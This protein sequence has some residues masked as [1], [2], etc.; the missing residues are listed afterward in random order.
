[1]R[2]FRLILNVYVRK[3][4]KNLKVN[5]AIPLLVALLA[6]QAWSTGA[7]AQQP[8]GADEWPAAVLETFRNPAG[9]RAIPTEQQIEWR[10]VAAEVE[11]S[12]WPNELLLREMQP[13]L[14]Q[15]FAA[16]QGRA[17]A[18]ALVTALFGD[19]FRGSRLD[20][21]RLARETSGAIRRDRWQV[22]SPDLD[23]ERFAASWQDRY[24]QYETIL[25]TEHY[26]DH[27]QALTAAGAWRLDVP[28]R[29]T[30][31][32]D[33][34]GLE[35]QGRMLVDLGR[36]TEG[37]SWQITRV[38]LMSFETFSSDV[39]FSAEPLMASGEPVDQPM[40]AYVEY[41]AQGVSVVDIDGDGDLDIF[42]PTRIGVPKLFINVGGRQFHE[43]G[44]ALGFGGVLGARS[45]YFFDWDND[46][47]QDALLLTV[48][49][50]FLFE[51]Q[52][53]RFVDVSEASS[54]HWMSTTGLT[55]ATV[56]DYD[57]DGLLDFYVANYG[58]LRNTPVEDYFDS[59]RGYENQ[60]FRNIGDGRFNMVTVDS[61]LND[62]NSRWSFAAL[63]FDYDEDD[64]QDLYV[65]NDYGPNQLFRNRGDMTFEDVAG[66]A[67]AS[68]F[69]NGMGVSL[70]DLDGDGREDLYVSNMISH[71]GKRMAAGTDF[72]GDQDARTLLH[73]FA[74][75]NTVLLARSGSFA[76]PETPVLS[77]AKWAWGNVLF[78]YDND[79]DLDVYVTNGMFSN[80][81]RSDTDP[82]FWRHLLAPVA[83]GK[84][85]G[86][87]AVG[88]FSYLLQQE[89]FSFAGYER[90]RL[91]Q[92]FGNATFRDVAATTGADLVLDSRSVAAGDLDADGD[93]DLVVASRNEPKL[94]VLWNE[95]R[96]PGTFVEVELQ[97][98]SS[99][100][101]GVG[102]VVDVTCDGRQQR[103]T[104]VVGSGYLSQGPHTLWFGLGQCQ[105]I[106][107]VAVR[108][109]T[110]VLTEARDVEAGAR[111]LAVEPPPED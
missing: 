15:F 19:E 30:G 59:R 98:T 73:R 102:A 52:D 92:N 99:N 27:M 34:G 109:P 89:S 41:F 35:D 87:Y 33:G 76:E 22:Y 93:L 105:S 40:Q 81:S 106:D 53:G 65:I 64:D 103:R 18:P 10:T 60:L 39:T 91:F 14:E 31:R 9:R 29:V 37:G 38:A 104:H 110:G 63:S 16:I 97:G 12:D 11:R 1:M 25:R 57:N 28:F 101:N 90:N 111:V 13:V 82:V 55:G 8:A 74:K 77:D 72:Q 43:A 46:G 47:D 86:A 61:G 3:S 32:A 4:L 69:G 36:D 56:A 79:A 7:H 83:A 23:A 94:V 84:P 88:Y 66:Q 70:G 58:D 54:F 17:F 71:A 96:A 50:M 45:G 108:W 78:D 21:R 44:E 67:G 95:L 107:R 62:D 2:K 100:R 6:I 48:T 80:L 26:V 42:A 85:A 68:D 75:G 5:G 51:Q 49:R 20:N 24:Q